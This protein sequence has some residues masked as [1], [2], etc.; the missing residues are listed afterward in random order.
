MTRPS[1]DLLVDVLGLLPGS[2]GRDGLAAELGSVGDWAPVIAEADRHFVLVALGPILGRAGLTARLPAEVA[3]VLALFNRANVARNARMTQA[4]EEVAAA[5]NAAGVVPVL[6]KGANRLI[7][8]L[9]PDAGLRVLSDLD[10]LVPPEQAMA[11]AGVLEALGFDWVAEDYAGDQAGR[12]QLPPMRRPA[13]GTRIELHRHAVHRPF[14]AILPADELMAAATPARLGRAEVAIPALR[15]QFLHLVIHDQLAN[16]G[17]RRCTLRL[18]TLL[19]GRLLLERL[20]PGE[21]EWV[22]RRLERHGRGRIG[23]HF[24]TMLDLWPVAPGRAEVLAATGAWQRL[25]GR[26]RIAVCLAAARGHKGVRRLLIARDVVGRLSVYG[27][28]RALASCTSPAFW[29]NRGKDVRELITA[30]GKAGGY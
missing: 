20:A 13:D 26:A 8:G 5:L 30:L 24:R 17:F 18:R 21:L 12:H 25:E 29:R 3:D 11:A 19:E 28:G 4:L 10:L 22:I 7:D 27:W 6:L 16:R 9:Y 23:R 15:H 14:A 2:T 1:F